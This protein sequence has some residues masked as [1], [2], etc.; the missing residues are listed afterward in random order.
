MSYS[1]G[2]AFG[3][4]LGP[5]GYVHSISQGG[6]AIGY[7]RNYAHIYSKGLGAF[8]FGYART[9]AEVKAYG[10]G[11]IAFGWANK[12]GIEALT[13]AE[14]YAYGKGSLAHGNTY[15]YARDILAGGHGSFASGNRGGFYT[16]DANGIGSFTHAAVFSVNTHADGKGSFQFGEGYNYEGYSVRIG[17]SFRLMMKETAVTYGPY[18][19]DFSIGTF[20]NPVQMYSGGTTLSWD[21][22]VIIGSKASNAALTSLLSYLSTMGIVNDLTS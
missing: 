13:V 3:R 10:D 5:K 4:A 2:L 8:A 16:M 6:V 12:S 21:H 18:P 19:G 1:G 22:P 17:S 7:A 11:S 14:I 20:T 9:S 15:G